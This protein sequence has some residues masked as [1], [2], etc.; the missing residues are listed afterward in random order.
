MRRKHVGNPGRPEDKVP[1]FIRFVLWVGLRKRR[2]LAA[3]GL[4]FMVL[5][6]SVPIHLLGYSNEPFWFWLFVAALSFGG[7]VL[8]GWFFWQLLIWPTLAF[9]PRNT[10]APHDRNADWE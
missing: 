7:G 5:I 9:Y 10:E 6:V 1:S 8:A 2:F 3:F 4:A